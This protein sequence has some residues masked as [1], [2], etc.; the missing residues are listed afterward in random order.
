M[1][2]RGV[3]EYYGIPPSSITDWKKGKTYTKKNGY[4]TYLIEVEE[5]S[6]VKWC[7]EM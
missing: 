2:I 6:L 7:F 4:K 3:R 1:S 5:L